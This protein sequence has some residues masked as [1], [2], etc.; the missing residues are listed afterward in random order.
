MMLVWQDGPPTKEGIAVV[1]WTNCGGFAV[2]DI[3]SFDGVVFA[4]H[5]Q[6]NSDDRCTILSKF[7]IKRHVM[8]PHPQFEVL[9]T[10]FSRGPDAEKKAR[11]S[12]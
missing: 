1:E 2:F 6:C 11:K 9:E 3:R 12:S 4:F 8:L 10:L 5:V 7:A